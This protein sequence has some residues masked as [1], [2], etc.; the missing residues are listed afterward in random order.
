VE[1]YDPHAKRRMDLFG[2]IDLVALDGA[3]GVLGI[4]TTTADH[5]AHRLTKLREGCAEPMGAVAECRQPA[6]DSRVG[7]AGP[8][9][10]R[11]VWTL[12]EVVVTAVE[13]GPHDSLK[14][15]GS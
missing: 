11:K 6:R 8:R 15:L 2:G 3:Q 4:Q 10:R 7:E 13:A 1:R 14:A 9:G 12:R 5:V